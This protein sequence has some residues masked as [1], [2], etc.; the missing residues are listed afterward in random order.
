[1]LKSNKL[2]SQSSSVLVYYSITERKLL[3]YTIP[4]PI[5]END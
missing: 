3:R 4:N 2:Y 5:N 1:M